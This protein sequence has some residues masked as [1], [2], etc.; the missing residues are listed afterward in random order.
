M[1]ASSTEEIAWSSYVRRA[2]ALPLRGHLRD[3]RVARRF[4]VQVADRERDLPAQLGRVR[5]RVLQ[6]DQ[7]VDQAAAFVEG[8][9]DA[10]E[11]EDEALVPDL[12]SRARRPS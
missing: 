12:R 3:L 4:D 10:I 8:R 5:A 9:R 1:T 7:H 11:G 6:P 2:A